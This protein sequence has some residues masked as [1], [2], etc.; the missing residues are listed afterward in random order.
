MKIYIPWFIKP[1]SPLKVGRR[2]GG[3]VKQETGMNQATIKA[4]LKMEAALTS[5]TS[6]DFQLTT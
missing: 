3:T 6:V 2:F 1:C 5:E 4:L